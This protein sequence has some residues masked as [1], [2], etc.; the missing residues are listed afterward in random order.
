MNREGNP[1]PVKVIGTVARATMDDGRYDD[2]EHMLTPEPPANAQPLS[3]QSDVSGWQI[4]RFTPGE[5][6]VNP[7]D[8][9]SAILALL[10]TKI[11]GV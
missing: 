5:P 2:G 6:G 8:R 1:V 3:F 9:R 10:V 11:L 7:F 4:A